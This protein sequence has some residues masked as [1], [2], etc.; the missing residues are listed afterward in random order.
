MFTIP[1]KSPE[2]TAPGVFGIPIIT[3]LPQT[4]G[5]PFYQTPAGA[6]S[7]AYSPGV[8]TG[9]FG[10]GVG[11]QAPFTR[12][13]YYQAPFQLQAAAPASS[14]YTS[15]A[16]TQVLPSGQR[17]SAPFYKASTD[18][19]Y[20]SMSTQITATGQGNPVH[21]SIACSS[22]LKGFGQRLTFL[23]QENGGN[24]PDFKVQESLNLIQ[25]CI[26]ER[27]ANSARYGGP[28]LPHKAVLDSLNNLG[29]FIADYYSN[30]K[31]RGGITINYISVN[32][33]FAIRLNNAELVNGRYYRNFQV[34]P[35]GSNLVSGGKRRGKEKSRKRNSKKSKTRKAH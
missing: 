18:P 7:S 9:A 32:D 4:V 26:N 14:I 6:I 34:T 21:S 10:K 22:D 29:K 12:N 1:R 8:T 33:G 27:T 5:A 15:A 3:Q 16:G 2:A 23:L 31:N 20:P 24:P 28:N 13:P 11:A 30:A 25:N 19:A 35:R 17:V